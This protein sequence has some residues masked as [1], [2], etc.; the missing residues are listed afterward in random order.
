M[1]RGLPDRVDPEKDSF[2]LYEGV[3]YEEFWSGSQRQNLDELD[4]WMVRRL[5]PPSGR[6]IVDVGCGYGRLADCYLDR[7]QQV[8][9][10]D[11]SMSLL[12]TASEKTKGQAVYIA[13]DAQRLPFR[14]GAF[15]AALLIRVFHHIDDSKACLSE[16]HRVTGNDGRFIFNY[17]NKR[18]AERVLHWLLRRK[19]SNPFS[20]EADS[21]GSTFISYHPKMV[22]ELLREVGF[23]EMKYYGLGVMDR[24]AAR[25]GVSKGGISLAAQLAPFLAWSKIAPWILCR[26]ISKENSNLIDT[27]NLTDILQCPSCGGDLSAE[28]EGYRCLLCSTH[29]PI[30]DGIIDFRVPRPSG[31]Q[32]DE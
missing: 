4:H 13:A 10:V 29:F 11:G 21:V 9:M 1:R 19:T 23:T 6:R 12:R 15:D 26:A 28:E 31:E 17:C 18:N 8:V 22:D 14:M 7:F 3:E 16:L 24:L 32:V 30:K 20:R 25:V 27:F 5:L 2:S